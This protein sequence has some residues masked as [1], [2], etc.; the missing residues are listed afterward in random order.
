MLIYVAALHFAPLDGGYT[1]ALLT[2]V[3]FAGIVVIFYLFN[4]GPINKLLKFNRPRKDLLLKIV[5]IA[6]LIAV[7]VSLTADLLNQSIFDRSQ[8]AYYEVFIDSPAPLILSIISIGLFPAVFEELAFRGILFNELIKITSI[9]SAIII[10]A[11]LFTIVHL[12]LISALWIFPIGLL[13]GYFRAKHKTLWYGI[14][15]HFV[16]NSSIVLFEMITAN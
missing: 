5:L 8:A 16:Y 2:D 12:S 11:I 9:K 3:F 14:A 6:P 13:F 7:L 4:P 10:S 15:G 1:Q